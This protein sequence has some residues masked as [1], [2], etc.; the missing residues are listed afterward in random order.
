MKRILY[1]QYTNPAGYPP[2]E[3]SSRMMA[4]T[5]WSVLFLGTGAWGA[6]VLEFSRHP[7]IEVKRM[8]FR[9]S[10]W[11]QKVH[12]TAYLIWC[13]WAV[14]TWRPRV[15][16]ASDSLSCPIAWPL[17][18]V[19]GLRV[20][21]HEH[22]TPVMSAAGGFFEELIRA[23]RRWLARRADLC[24]LPNEVRLKT[25]VA[26]MG[27][28]RNSVC[29]WNCPASGEI[30]PDPRG[31]VGS[32]VRIVYHG[33]IV[34]DRLPLTVVDALALLGNSVCLRVV[35][36]ETVGS[37]GYVEQLRRRAEGLGVAGRVEFLGALPQRRDLLQATRQS[38]IGLAL[39]PMDSNDLNLKT[40]TGASNKAFDYLGCGL[41]LVVSEL[42]DWREVFV[43]AGYGLAC[44]P[45]DPQSIA[46]AIQWLA[47][48][49][50]RMRAM[51]EAGR[52]KTL[53]EWNYECT[54]R[55]VLE[56]LISAE[57]SGCP[58]Q[59]ARQPI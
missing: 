31:A 36:Y 11:R 42:S 46:G 24:I 51:G 32:T 59:Q 18:W 38:D 17:T 49:P 16:Y 48:H 14:L 12:Y 1:I 25:F 22:D 19:P 13:V 3:H 21:Y 45:R 10:G 26:E 57:G 23:T 56:F 29:V 8:R 58:V 33:S 41:A 52:L 4:E 37:S 50:E 5:G 44:D 30:T 9:A 47:D 39:M 34:P 54:F 15:V 53:T 20:V 43:D 28:V 55:P 2:L 27:S 35:G 6:D 40:M 7:G